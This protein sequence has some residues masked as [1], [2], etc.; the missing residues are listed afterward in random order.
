MNAS[1]RIGIFILMA[2]S[3]VEFPYLDAL[4]L[5]FEYKIYL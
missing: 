4:R 2:G 5:I 1:R 3:V